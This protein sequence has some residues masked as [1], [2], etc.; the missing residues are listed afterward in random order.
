MDAVS[1]VL[2]RTTTRRELAR[3]INVSP[4]VLAN[5]E[6]GGF[7]EPENAAKIASYFGARPTEMWDG[8]SDWSNLRSLRTGARQTCKT[9][10]EMVGVDAETFL[11]WE[12]GE[13]PIPD[14]ATVELA[15][16]YAVQI[17]YLK[18]WN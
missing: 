16:R 1:A 4:K 5:V 2:D 7:P 13:E 9:A 6:R 17:H 15:R 10:G 14:E 18:G 3:R 8:E 12:Q 11:R